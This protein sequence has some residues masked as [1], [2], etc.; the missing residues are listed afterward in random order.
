MF[1]TMKQLSL[2]RRKGKKRGRKKTGK[3]GVPHRTRPRLNGRKFPVHV[4][5]RVRA[6]VWYLRS[7]RCWR[8]IERAFYSANNR[9]GLRLVDF[10]V[11][12]NHVHLI[13]EASDEKSLAKGM[14]GLSIRM[15]KGLNKIMGTSGKVFADRY[16]ARILFS[17]T[18]VQNAVAYVI[19]NAQHHGF[20]PQAWVEYNSWRHRELVSPARTTLL[21]ECIIPVATVERLLRAGDSS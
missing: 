19:G 18:Q 21:T 15:A 16:H 17:R 3:A 1:S 2:F 12:G 13:V 7:R 14:Q 9:F 5:L 11:M 10:N 6:G 20:P 4:T 8:P